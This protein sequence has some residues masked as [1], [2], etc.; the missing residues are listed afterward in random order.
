MKRMGAVVVMLLLTRGAALADDWLIGWN[1]PG[2]HVVVTGERYVAGNVYVLNQAQLELAPGSRLVVSGEIGLLGDGMLRATEATIRF[3][4]SFA[5]QCALVAGGTA[6]FD[7]VDVRINGNGHSFSI[8][9][10][11]SAAARF[12][13]VTVVDGFATWGFYEEGSAELSDC[14]NAGE[15]VPFG[16][17]SLRISGS[18]TVLLWLTLFDG[19]VIDTQLPPPGIVDEFRLNPQTPWATNIPYSIHLIDCENTMW[20]L[21]ARSGSHAVLHSSELRVVG[22]YFEREAAVTIAGIANDAYYADTEWQWGDITYRF[23][24]S[25]IQTWNFY[26]YGDSRVEIHDSVFGEFLV[27]GTGEAWVEQCLC[28]GSGGYMGAFDDGTLYLVFGA[29]LSQMT[30]KGNA[31]LIAF[32]S[33][34]MSHQVDATDLSVMLLVNSQ[35][36]SEPRA[37]DSATIMA[38][39]VDPVSAVRGEKIPVYGTAQLI[40]G[41]TSPLQFQGFIL[42]Y[43]TDPSPETWRT[44]TPLTSSQVRYGILGEWDTAAL[45]PGPYTLRLSLF[46]NFEEPLRAESAAEVRPLVRPPDL[47]GDGTV[48]AGD[49]GILLSAFMRNDSGDLDGDGDT[50]STD[51]QLLLVNFDFGPSP[52][53]SVAARETG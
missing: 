31:A 38:A 15:F 42:E 25:R 49:L 20:S 9:L 3:T 29:N 17:G 7:F 18:E 12:T 30:C 51:L 23:V 11:G 28:D 48:N 47:D 37:W 5:Y 35:T 39:R 34:L 14:R 8:G 41:P 44:V 2:E 21:M 6:M 26:C 19:T 1:D 32:H 53:G 36:V 40:R 46:H 4:Q 52:T 45:T 27:G 43:G 22:S 16:R 24:D 13:R 10:A 50:D 33:A